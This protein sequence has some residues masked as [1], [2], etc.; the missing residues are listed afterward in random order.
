MYVEH[1]HYSHYVTYNIG[2]LFYLTSSICHLLQVL[3]C[4]CMCA[5]VWCVSVCVCGCMCACVWCVCVYVYGVSVCVV[6]ECMCVHVV[7]KVDRYDL[8]EKTQQT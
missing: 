3:Q 4:V 8:Y 7:G 5:C 1:M 2:S 6:C